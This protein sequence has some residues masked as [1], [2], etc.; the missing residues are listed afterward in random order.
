MRTG[1][2][3]ARCQVDSASATAHPTRSTKARRKYSPSK[4]LACTPS[5]QI[6]SPSSVVTI[7]RGISHLLRNAVWFFKGSCRCAEL[8]ERSAFELADALG[9]DAEPTGDFTQ[10]RSLAIQPEPGLQDRALAV[11]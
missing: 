7:T 2:A 4:S 6:I 9:A 5:F 8:S 1:R 3:V 10:T 11:A